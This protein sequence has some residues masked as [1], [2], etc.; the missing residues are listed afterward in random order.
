M[1]TTAA[2]QFSPLLLPGAAFNCRPGSACVRT[3]RGGWIGEKT[4]ALP[5]QDAVRKVPNACLCYQTVNT[6]RAICGGGEHRST[7]GSDSW[8]LEGGRQVAGQTAGDV[9]P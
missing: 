1:T 7:Y 8:L 3:R 9:R 4:G 5:E 6:L 2:S